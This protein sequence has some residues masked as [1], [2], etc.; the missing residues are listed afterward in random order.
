MQITH[1]SCEKP[2]MNQDH[3]PQNLLFVSNRVDTL[4]VLRLVKK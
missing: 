4:Q 2:T 3:P 1:Y